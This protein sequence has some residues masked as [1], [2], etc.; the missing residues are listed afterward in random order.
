MKNRKYLL[1]FLIAFVNIAVFAADKK[2]PKPPAKSEVVVVFA[3]KIKPEPNT[4]FFSNYRY[5][6]SFSSKL[7]TKDSRDMTDRITIKASNR[8]V[9]LLG[10]IDE[11]A[12]KVEF[13]MVKLPFAYGQRY[14]NIEALQYHFAG[15]EPLR[16][17]IPL[18]GKL[19]VP[20]GVK[21]VYIGDFVCKCALPFYDITDVK[22]IDNFDAAAKAVKEMY[23]KDAELERI[24]LIP[25][26]NK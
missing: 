18:N 9:P 5:A 10:L 20:E 15:T 4:D 8:R 11:D 2:P 23:G 21:Y 17:S 24:P 25:I 1:L 6:F 26:E 3:L 16:I 7:Q 22:K 14:I 13:A 12:K 19:E